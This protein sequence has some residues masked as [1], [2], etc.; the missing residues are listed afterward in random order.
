MNQEGS[1]AGF[2]QRRQSGLHG[3]RVHMLPTELND[4]NSDKDGIRTGLTNAEEEDVHIDNEYTRM[5]SQSSLEGEEDFKFRRRKRKNG[6]LGERLDNLQ[7]M[8]N[9]KWMDNFNSSVQQAAIAS[10]IQ[11]YNQISQTSQMQPH[12][13]MPYV[14]YYMPP[15]PHMMAANISPLKYENN[16]PSSSMHG[17]PNTSTQPFFPQ[18]N[19]SQFIPSTQIYPDHYLHDDRHRRH[20]KE[21]KRTLQSQRGKRLSMLS[22]RGDDNVDFMGSEI[23]SPHKDVPE[24]DF[25]KHIGNTSFGRGLQTR[26]L[27]NWCMIRC[28]KKLEVEEERATADNN[29]STYVDPRRISLVILKEFVQDIRKGKD[30]VNWEAD[31]DFEAECNSNDTEDT[32]LRELFDEAEDNEPGAHISTRKKAIKVVK[33]PN[34]K[35]IQNQKN[36][37][38][39]QEKISELKQ[40]VEKWSVLLDDKAYREKCRPLKLHTHTQ[41]DESELNLPVIPDVDSLIIKFSKRI[42]RFQASTHLLYS[43]ADLLGNTL[44]AKAKAIFKALSNRSKQEDLKPRKRYIKKLLLGLSKVIVPSAHPKH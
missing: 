22:L 11:P 29:N 24:S 14:Y 7:D 2:L 41:I 13:Y 28:L 27:F 33:V 31:N 26:Q 3:V 21:R 34:E 4:L 37:V 10:H 19:N 12:Q 17:L 6:A 36:I 30:D 43:H 1:Y 5:R 38:I 44:T 23:I 18:L 25:Y 42:D 15:P 35:N 39:L 16:N 9:A 40:E 20:S 32:E 8:Q